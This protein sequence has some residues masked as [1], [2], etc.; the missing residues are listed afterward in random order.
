MHYD[1]R[2]L[3]SKLDGLPEVVINNKTVL[4]FEPNNVENLC[5]KINYLT[6]NFHKAKVLGNYGRLFL[7]TEL[8]AEKSIKIIEGVLKY[9]AK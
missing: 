6:D 8:N 2:C 9:I 7:V 4:L 1:L 3:T 5:N